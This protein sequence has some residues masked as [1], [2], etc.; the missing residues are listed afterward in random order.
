[1]VGFVSARSAITAKEPR[2]D[3]G[4]R[5]KDEL[6]VGGADGERLGA[7]RAGG[8]EIIVRDHDGA[9]AAGGAE[10]VGKGRDRL[11]ADSSA[12]ATIGAIDLGE[13]SNRPGGGGGRQP[14]EEQHGGE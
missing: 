4:E 13:E 7:A 14:R 8:D 3:V 5:V 1:M 2:E 12:G 10:R 6:A 11:R 9:R